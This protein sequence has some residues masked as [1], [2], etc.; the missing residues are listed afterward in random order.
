MT[1][2]TPSLRRPCF[3]SSIVR[4][5]IESLFWT[6]VSITANLDSWRG[7]VSS[8]IAKA[9][10]R[11]CDGGGRPG[12]GLEVF[13]ISGEEVAALA[14]FGILHGTHELARDLPRL[15]R[16]RDPAARLPGAGGHQR[17]G[18]AGQQKQAEGH[19]EQ[20]LQQG[21]KLVVVVDM[22]KPGE[23]GLEPSQGHVSRA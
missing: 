17:G 22:E 5:T 3:A 11:L 2:S 14:D 20:G 6:S 21:C 8:L 7:I 4:S 13:R 9:L 16:V 12:V 10:Q 18:E 15:D 23:P 1:T 19:G